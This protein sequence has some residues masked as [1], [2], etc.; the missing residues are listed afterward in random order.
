MC[1]SQFSLQPAVKIFMCFQKIIIHLK[2]ITKEIV[3]DAHYF[4]GVLLRY[5]VD[6]F[7]VLSLI[8]WHVDYLKHKETVTHCLVSSPNFISGKSV[9]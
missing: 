8:K 7:C 3:A 4:P 5:L 2:S 9:L 6:L 1:V